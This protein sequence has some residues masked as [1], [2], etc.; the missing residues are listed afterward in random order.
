LIVIVIY[1]DDG[2]IL[3]HQREDIVELLVQQNEFEIT[4]CNKVSQ[5]L[6]FQIKRLDNGN[7]KIHQAAYA[8]KTLEM[9]NMN[10]SR[11]CTY[12]QGVIRH[13]VQ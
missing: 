11:S 13:I 10:D 1:V 12:R 5:F 8:L 4:I 9:F 6:G 7:I 3:A 2:L